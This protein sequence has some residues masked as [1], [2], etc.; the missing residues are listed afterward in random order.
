MLHT[1]H[2]FLCHSALFLR[3]THVAVYTATLWLC[4]FSQRQVPGQGHQFASVNNGV[5]NIHQE[6]CWVGDFVLTDTTKC[7]QT[8]LQNNLARLRLRLHCQQHYTRLLMSPPSGYTGHIHFLFFE[9]PV[10]IKW[11]FFF[12]Q[13][14]LTWLLGLSVSASRSQ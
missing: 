12:F 6:N 13:F 8:V 2:W 11:L 5:M 9:N 14:T 3:S 4:K 1:S 10:G 7:C